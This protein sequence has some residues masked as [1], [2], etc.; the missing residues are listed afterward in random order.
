MFN[1]GGLKVDPK[2]LLAYCQSTRHDMLICLEAAVKIESP[3]ASKPDVDRMARFCADRFR[4]LGGRVQLLRH[5]TAGSA[6]VAEF[7][8]ARRPR[9]P[10]L[11]LGH[12]DTVWDVGT[13][14]AMPFHL[15][16]GR[17]Y[18]PG[19][20]DMKSGIVC[21]LWAIRALRASGTVPARPVRW[22][23]VV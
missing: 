2:R 6:V 22:K 23:S 9:K 17:A 13:L 1:P 16:G 4:E 11:L 19:I 7:W 20:F 18:G 14:K 5:S 21:G 12:L 15:R 8:S 3:T 10:V